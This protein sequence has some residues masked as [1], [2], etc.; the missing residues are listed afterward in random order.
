MK[1][2]IVKTTEALHDEVLVKNRSKTIVFVP[3]MGALHAGHMSLVERGKRIPNALIVVSIFVNP[4][5]F[6]PNEDFSRYPRTL[7]ADAEMLEKAGANVLFLPDV[8]TIY[9][10]GYETVVS[11]PKLSKRWD[12]EHRPGHF[13]G[14]ATVVARLFGLVMPEYAIFGEKDFQQLAIIRRMVEDLA[15][16]PYIIGAPT[17]REVDGLAM[18]SRNRYLNEDERRIA[19][20]LYE[21]LQSLSKK[22]D[23]EAIE[24]AKHGLLESGFSKIDYLALVDTDTLEPLDKPKNPARLLAAAWLGTTRLI[25]NIEVI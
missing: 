13:D 17:M 22:A 18:S 6:G 9:P 23:R 20:K 19:P 11:L 10:P 21:T 16:S 7:D 25:D 12:G 1:L 5:Q 24:V 2:A 15:L 8:E 4:T 3:T 14:V